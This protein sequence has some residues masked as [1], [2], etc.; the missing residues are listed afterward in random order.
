VHRSRRLL[1]AESKATDSQG[2]LIARGSGNFMRSGIR[3][4][5]LE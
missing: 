4:D 5:G 3:L 2:N 1:I